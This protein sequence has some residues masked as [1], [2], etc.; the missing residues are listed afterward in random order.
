MSVHTQENISDMI[1]LGTTYGLETL[2]ITEVERRTYN[3]GYAAIHSSY[4]FSPGS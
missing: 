2:E 3:D 4:M 1:S